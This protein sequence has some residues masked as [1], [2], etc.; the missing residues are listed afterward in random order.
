VFIILNMSPLWRTTGSAR[1]SAAGATPPRGST[2]ARDVAL[3]CLADGL[4]G[5]SFGATAV[6]GGLPWWVP[7]AMSLL[8]FAGGSQIAAVGVVLS[9]GSPFA[10]VAAGAVL[11][12][13]LFPYGLAVADVVGAP[14][15]AAAGA[16]GAGPAVRRWL[17]RL[18]GAQIITDESVAFALRQ[19]DPARRRA[20]F[21]TCGLNL[22][23]AWN[24]AVLLG[25]LAGSVVRNT[26]A[27][28]LDATFPAVLIA[29]ALPA[30]AELRT[31]V[32]AGT[33]AVIAVALTPVLPAGLPVLAALAGLA[34]GWRPRGRTTKDPAPPPADRRSANRAAPSIDPLTGER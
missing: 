31:R 4:V 27:F 23:G 5:L 33:G 26:N 32:S 2:L 29:L 25:V 16:G 30:L 12:T 19:T 1:S 7:V 15:H 28:G 34:T 11:N 18:L 20:A 8:V 3:V 9:G 22:F 21:W 6:A 13:R 10:A 24:V 17:I 14:D